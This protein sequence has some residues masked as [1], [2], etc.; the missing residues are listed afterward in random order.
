MKRKLSLSCV[1]IIFGGTGD[2]THRKIMPAL[3]NLSCENK[4]SKNF[5]VVCVGRRNLTNAEYLSQVEES[6]KMFSNQKFDFNKWNKLKEKIYYWKEGFTNDESYEGLS[7]LLEK[8]DKNHNTVGNRIFYLAVAPEFFNLIVE[9]MH[10]HKMVQN[11]NSWQRV[12]IEKPFGSDLESAAQLNNSINKVFTE[13]NTYRIDHYLGKEMLQNIMV[14]R[15]ANAIFAPVWSNRYIDNIQI[16]SSEI[17]GVEQRGG[18]Y[19][20]SGAL[21]D[22]V[23]NH[24][25]Q[26]LALIAMEP[27]KDL[28]TESIRD[29]KV[30]VL[31][32][33]Q[34]LKPEIIKKNIV[35]G[36]YGSG[37][38]NG[39]NI[40][41]YREEDR[42]F[43]KSNV[44]TFVAMKV[45]IDN[46]R[47]KGVPFYIRTGKRMSRKTTYIV[48]EFKQ[49]VDSPYFMRNNNLDTNLLV[50]RISPKEGAYF[51]F[52]AKRPGSENIIVPVKMDFCQN[53]RIDQNSPEAYEKLVYDVIKGD[54][55]QFSRWDEVKYSWKFVES[56][57]NVW[58]NEVPA[59]PNYEAGSCGP[60][61]ADDLINA[62]GKKWWEMEDE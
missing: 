17:V 7:R 9:K 49:V 46:H 60:K 35:R 19:E 54:S 15:F 24:M 28:N 36:Q 57:A 40:K 2:L 16:S 1:M 53:C 10:K 41:S 44:E 32:S 37:N 14:I 39:I 30:D 6:I 8:L 23:Q 34:K 62:D 27:P 42:V 25:L 59:F 13:K 4:I 45:Y 26:M 61:E 38:V 31:G 20:N 21:R 29:S 50:I 48:I 55:T 22:M 47:W 3:Y 12:V 11:N 52:N 18:Y 5:A 33:I 51:Q 56:I 58:E 43:K